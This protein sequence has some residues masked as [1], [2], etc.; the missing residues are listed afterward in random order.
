MQTIC[1]ALR[2]GLLLAGLASALLFHGA[3][4]VRGATYQV[5]DAVTNFYLVNRLPWTNDL[6]QRVPAGAPL[7]LSDFAGKI[8]FFELFY[9]W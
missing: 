9:Y 1:H 6:G 7:R 2:C 8:A 5:G 4:Q 3:T